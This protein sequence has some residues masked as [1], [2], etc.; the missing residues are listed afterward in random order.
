MHTGRAMTSRSL[1]D[2]FGC[3]QRTIYRD[4]DL[5]RQAG[6]DIDFDEVN[7]GYALRATKPDLSFALNEYE[8]TILVLAVVTSPLNEYERYKETLRDV[9]AK[10]VG[11]AED[12]L[13][14]ETL[15]LLQSFVLSESSG[16]RHDIERNADRYCH[17]VT[18]TG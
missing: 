7:G 11:S 8:H 9:H 10:L 3:S 2:A 16:T 18:R 13:E 14:D 12:F 17:P 5:L 4:L 15:K 1:A 6:A